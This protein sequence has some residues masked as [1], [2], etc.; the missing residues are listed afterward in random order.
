MDMLRRWIAAVSA[1]ALLSANCAM[2]PVSAIAQ[3][4]QDESGQINIVITD[5]T[6]SKP[7]DMAR[8]LL[9]GPVITTEFS[10]NDGKV[11]FLDVPDGIYRAR[12]IKRGYQ[13]VTSSEFEV[14][15]GRAVAVTI[16]LAPSQALKVIASVSATST[17]TVSTSTITNDSAQ[18]KLST[19]LVDALGKL[20]GVTIST[21]SDDS[22]A[23]E[24]VSLTGHDASQTALTLDG[25]PLNAPGTAGDLGSLPTDLFGGASVS[26]GPQLGGL[27]GGVSFR[28]AEPTISWQGNSQ[29][30]VG[31]NGRNNYLFGETGSIGKLGIAMN[32]SQRTT[33][34][35]VDGM[36]YTDASG[37]D[38][39]HEGDNIIDGQLL[40]LRY[41]LGDSQTLEAEFLG[42][43]RSTG[44]VCLRITGALPCGYGPGNT[45]SNTTQLF[46]LSDD[47]LI[48]DTSVQ[49]SI[50]GMSIFNNADELDRYVAGVAEPLGYS[51]QNSTRGFNVQAQLPA[52]ERHTLSIQF[53]GSS[54]SVTTTPLI[55][56]AIP[57]YNGSEATSYTAL[58]LNDTIH[59]N[60]KLTLN[61][62]FG[63]NQSTNA[64]ASILASAGATW[65]PT[66]VD[67]F[68]GSYA[69]GGVAP[70][71]GRAQILTDPAS[72][73]FD[74]NGNV[75][76]GQAPGDI[77]GASSSTS[78]NLSY[79]HNW[80]SAQLS[81]QLYR[82]VQNGVVLP[83][84]VNGTVLNALGQFPAGYLA[85]VEGVY[86]SSAGCGSVPPGFGYQNLYFNTP[87]GG[88]RHIY[89]GGMLTGFVTWKNLVIQPYYDI[90]GSTEISNDIRIN[91]P[92][93]IV[94]SGS[95]VPNTPMHTA[96][97]TLDYR[98]PHSALE[99]LADAQYVGAN[100]Q[101]NLP[102]YTRIDAGA[103]AQLTRG[104]LTM[105]MENVT[106]QYGGIFASPLNAV[107]YQTAGG[108]I[109]PTI[110]RPLAPRTISLTYTVRFG[111]GLLQNS[112]RA[113]ASAMFGGRRGGPGGPSGAGSPGGDEGYAGGGGPG[114]TGAGAP[115][116]G[117]GGFRALF[118]PIPTTPP[119][120]PLAVKPVV[121]SAGSPTSGSGNAGGFAALACTADAAKSAHAI[122]DPLKAYVAQIEAAKKTLPASA[123]NG[124][125]T[126]EYPATFASPNIPGLAVTYHGLGTTYAL[127]LTLT[128]GANMRSIFPCATMHLAQAADVQT[129][130]LY[131]PQNSVF[132]VPQLT[133]MPEVGLYIA[134][135]PQQAGQES[136]RLYKLPTK[137]PTAPFAVHALPQCTSD[138][139]TTA[140]QALNELQAHFARGAAAPSW[141]IVTHQAK[142]GTWFELTPNDINV[143]PT[144]LMC[145]RIATGAP[146]DLT[147]LGY[148]GARPPAL[149]YTP[150]LGLY[151]VRNN[152]GGG[153]GGNGGPGAN[154]SQ[155]SNGNG[156]AP[157]VSPSPPP[158][159]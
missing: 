50:Y 1:L 112:S 29:L 107:P 127:S 135:R 57:Y 76:Y 152:F 121:S 49:A 116:G 40:K 139:K 35:L 94:I 64:P 19:D 140:I 23:T 52:K 85:L 22:D 5:A 123:T 60:T 104:T 71:A 17:A 109:I 18:R 143:L 7:V 132:F 158:P 45:R 25:I 15:E 144:L 131:Q 153:Q 102:A 31:S 155:N 58:Q 63:L 114:G 38:Y 42:S 93:S 67:S 133:F 65:K 68:S 82:Q 69:V 125:S 2:M 124:A 8:I 111:Q 47:A 154:G 6:T 88:I 16:S 77:P 48:G 87:V 157:G 151:F 89:Q 74:C 41:E 100:N 147:A 21:S 4:D 9:D 24:T 28:T 51:T 126:V 138:L 115:G 37:L 46:S 30:S 134:P 62:S 11:D 130:H 12:I 81:A 80:R 120:D 20:S 72:L 159:K 27:G 98:S 83:V 99:Y 61:D 34:S 92:Y 96:G 13:S 53:Y 149:N 73:Q 66:K 106:N 78:A 117:R 148:D 146:T 26:F 110:A 91:N 122:L 39:T 43:Q 108:I 101:N 14:V 128:N 137:P 86:A 79:T 150:A 129:Y 95:Q 32:L 44:I 142:S 84:Q 55:N 156:A 75:V 113:N 145:G 141:Q 105:A 10:S 97:L 118:A 36:L 3:S 33:P 56:A 119:T 90:T 59:S 54:T 103:S 136:F 70:N